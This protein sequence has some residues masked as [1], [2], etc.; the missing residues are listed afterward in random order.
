MANVPPQ[1]TPTTDSTVE[2]TTNTAPQIKSNKKKAIPWD[3]DGVN[4]GC[5]L[6]T[7]TEPT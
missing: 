1:N 6:A 2:K 7:M 3:R 4:G 5:Q